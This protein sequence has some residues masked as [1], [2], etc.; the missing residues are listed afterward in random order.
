MGLSAKTF[1]GIREKKE[2]PWI[3][4]I[5]KPFIGHMHKTDVNSGYFGF[6]RIV[7]HLSGK[8]KNETV[9][10]VSKKAFCLS[11]CPM[12]PVKE[13][14]DHH[15][16]NVKGMA[17][18][19]ETVGANKESEDSEEESEEGASRSTSAAEAKKL[20]LL[21]EDGK[22]RTI[23]HSNYAFAATDGEKEAFYKHCVMRAFDAKGKVRKKFECDWEK[24]AACTKAIGK[25]CQ[26]TMEAFEFE[27][28]AR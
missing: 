12:V 24:P 6:K 11:K 3:A 8:Y 18:L 2:D 17:L 21:S 27:L 22:M 26:S 7:L 15:F 20:G 14:K 10:D 9:A 19:S 23:F 25:E 16:K 13:I 28:A 5:T 1:P 4:V